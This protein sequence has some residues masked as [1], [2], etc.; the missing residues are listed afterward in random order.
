[1]DIL[2]RKPTLLMKYLFSLLLTFSFFLLGDL[3]AAAWQQKFAEAQEGDFIVTAQEGHYSLLFIRSL[4]TDTLLLEEISI[5]SNQIELKKIDWKKWVAKKA[6]GH[7]SWT[8]FE[9]DRV[10]GKLLTCFSFSKNGWLHLDD[11]EQFLPR[12]LTLS[13]APVPLTERKKIGPQPPYG[14][15]DRRALWTPPLVVEGKKIPKPTFDVLKAKWPADGSRLSLCRFEL[16][17]SKEQPTFPFPYWLEIHS[18]HYTFK[19]RAVDSGHHL[20]S[21]MHCPISR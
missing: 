12:L 18:P 17:F 15:E 13:L 3:T 9:I 5:P 6:P 14:E 20:R 16:Y 1:M 11:S 8:L 4:N 2:F 7:T 19:M 10:A 21:P